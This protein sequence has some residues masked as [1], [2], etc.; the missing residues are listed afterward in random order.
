MLIKV[1]SNAERLDKFLA[2]YLKESRS[3]IS[4]IIKGNYVLVNGN[5]VK[6]S[7]NV[8]ENDLI[9]VKDNYKEKTIIAPEDIH[10]DIIFEDNDIIVINKPSG[11]VVHPTSFGQG[12]LVNALMHHTEHLSDVNGPSR[13]G[14]V[15]RLD[16]DT[17]GLM[18][19]AKNNEAHHIL[20]KNFREKTIKR[21]YIA[22]LI[23]DFPHGSATI[24]APL[25]RDK[26]HKEKRTVKEGGKNALTYLTTLK[27]YEG[28]TLVKLNLATGRTHQIRV[29]MS[30]IGYPIYNDPLYSKKVAD[31]F[32]QFL[33]SATLEFLHPITKKKMHFEADLPS[34]FANFVNNL[35]EK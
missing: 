11:L 28:F 7:Y 1:K 22:L 13:R 25:G 20:A 26:V 6:S 14:I 29:H 8:E 35:V 23:G 24:D 31:K 19:V 30:Y 15:H 21:E 12:T 16:K 34:E 32:G 3:V 10:L 33:H 4:R 17:S 18:L 5:S 9:E 2:L 27:R